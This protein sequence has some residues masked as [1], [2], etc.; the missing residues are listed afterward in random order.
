[1]AVR[2]QGLALTVQKGHDGAKGCMQPC[3]RVA[4]REVGSHWRHV[5]KTI[6][7]PALH[8]QHLPSSQV[9]RFGSHSSCH[10][11][12]SQVLLQ[13]CAVKIFST[14]Q[15]TMSCIACPEKS[16]CHHQ[17]EQHAGYWNRLLMTSSTAAEGKSSG[18][19]NADVGCLSSPWLQAYFHDIRGC[20][21]DQ[22]LVKLPSSRNCLELY[23]CHFHC[24]RKPRCSLINNLA[25]VTKTVTGLLNRCRFKLPPGLLRVSQGSCL[26]QIGS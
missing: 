2:G 23:Q 5:R 21:A 14:V 20:A 11:H 10:K 8:H 24:V 18:C 22:H 4:V 15:T 12:C 26:S 9:Y 6:Q 16:L 19:G 25:M 13:T 3:E 1:M 17:P 7:M